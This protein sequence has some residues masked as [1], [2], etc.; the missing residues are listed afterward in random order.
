MGELVVCAFLESQKFVSGY[1]YTGSMSLELFNIKW[2]RTR[3]MHHWDLLRS[4]NIFCSYLYH[5]IPF[6]D[7]FSEHRN[8][9]CN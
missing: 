3:R 5:T 1:G 6:Y 9:S 7:K 4:W 8:D 2:E